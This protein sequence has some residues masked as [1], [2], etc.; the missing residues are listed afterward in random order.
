MKHKG[1]CPK[2]LRNYS[3]VLYTEHHILPKRHFRGSWDVIDLCRGC[4]NEIERL[5]PYHPILP[6]SVYYLIVNN[7]IGHHVVTAPKEVKRNARFAHH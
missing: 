3:D 6:V 7:F 2:C 1:F 5:I 4:H